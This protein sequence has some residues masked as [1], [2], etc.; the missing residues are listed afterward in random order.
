M[1]ER[2]IRF[3]VIGGGL[4]GRELASAA[5]RWIHLADLGVRPELAVVCDTNP[6]ALAWFERLTPRPRLVSDYRVL[7][8]DDSVEAIYCAVPHSLHEELFV[9]R[10]EAEKPLLGETPFGIALAES[11]AIN[12]AIAARPAARPLL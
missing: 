5:A 9:P 12:R 3:G 7:L 1:A 8:A 11:D 2:A 10:L 6:D 4:I